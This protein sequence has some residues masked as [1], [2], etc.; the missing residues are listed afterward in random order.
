MITVNSVTISLVEKPNRHLLMK[1]GIKAT[2]YFEYV[3]EVGCQ[4]WEELK[5]FPSLNNEPVGV[6]LP[7]HLIKPGTST[8][9]HGTEVATDIFFPI[10]EGYELIFL[11]ACTYLKFQGEPYSDENYEKEIETVQEVIETFDPATIGYQL[12]KDQPRIQ[13]EPQGTRGYLEL[14]GAKKNK[15]K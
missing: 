7:S 10:P 4:I 3:N 1:R 2:H 9:V 11:P 6:W 12:D 8:Y 15:L 5:Q 13:L 14:I